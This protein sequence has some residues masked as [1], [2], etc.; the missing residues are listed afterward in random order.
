M[1]LKEWEKKLR[2]PLADRLLMD[3]LLNISR[4]HKKD[5]PRQRRRTRTED[6]IEECVSDDVLLTTDE[7]IEI[8][9]IELNNTR[10][11]ALEQDENY[12]HIVHPMCQLR[13]LDLFMSDDPQKEIW[14]QPLLKESV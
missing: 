14:R 10:A 7:G 12:P 8:G 5:G 1:E 4:H 3:H 13:G 6:S 11:T 9:K 2:E